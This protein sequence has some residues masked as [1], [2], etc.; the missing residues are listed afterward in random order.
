MC[1]KAIRC[2]T[3]GR[4]R[5]G[6][7]LKMTVLRRLAVLGFLLIAAMPQGRA[8]TVILDNSHSL[9]LYGLTFSVSSCTITGT[10]CAAAGLDLSGVAAGRGNIE[11]EVVN[12]SG[13]SNAILS[14]ALT[15]ASGSSTLQFT[16]GVAQTSGQPNTLATSAALIDTGIRNYTC[17]SGHSGCSATAS[18]SLN[19]SNITITT[20]PLTQALTSVQPGSQISTSPTDTATG[21]HT[22]SFV[23]TLTLTT[24]G[25]GTYNTVGTLQLNTVAVL[26]RAAPEPAS[27]AVMMVALGGLAVVRRR[28]G[29]SSGATPS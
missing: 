14:R 18:A 17:A 26:F 12:P 7:D 28:R 1:H 13:S 27:M 10:T 19:F 24:Q 2:G 23:E 15:S 5:W 3:F 4:M 21:D 6:L 8:Q 9:A 22:F 29:A 25:N 20:D 16:I 11:F